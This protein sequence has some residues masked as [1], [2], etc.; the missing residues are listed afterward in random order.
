MP[1]GTDPLQMRPVI[2]ECD[3][4][5][6]TALQAH[7]LQ[8]GLFCP[9]LLPATYVQSGLSIPECS[10]PRVVC[11]WH[12]GEK[13]RALSRV[14]GAV[15]KTAARWSYSRS[16]PVPCPLCSCAAADNAAVA[17]WIPAVAFAIILTTAS[18]NTAVAA[19]VPAV[20]FA[21]ILTT[22]SG[23]TAVAPDDCP[24]EA[25]KA[26]AAAAVAAVAVTTGSA[27]ATA[28]GD[29]G[30][31]PSR[32]GSASAGNTAGVAL[33]GNAVATGSTVNG[34]VDKSQVA[35]M[36]LLVRGSPG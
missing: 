16:A 36:L 33:S 7:A 12:G 27:E 6:L 22:A 18:G 32:V 24:A 10:D 20:A 9:Q 17:A 13:V 30:G 31:T 26:V 15:A 8:Q 34:R 5:A 29:S 19:W 2:T 11:E 14:A 21:I 23:T 35:D 3:A 28:T 1:I 4:S 25:D